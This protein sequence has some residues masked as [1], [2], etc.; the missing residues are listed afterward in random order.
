MRHQLKQK[1]G[2][3]CDKLFCFGIHSSNTD[4]H[5]LQLFYVKK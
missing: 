2:Q 3:H 5:V 4:N 1:T